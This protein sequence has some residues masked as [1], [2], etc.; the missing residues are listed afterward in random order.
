MYIYIPIK[1]RWKIKT[2]RIFHS[3]WP[4][5]EQSVQL[6]LLDGWYVI[7]LSFECLVHH[8]VFSKQYVIL[9]SVSI[10]ILPCL[11]HSLWGQGLWN[12]KN[13]KLIIISHTSIKVKWW[14]SCIITLIQNTTDGTMLFVYPYTRAAIFLFLNNKR[15]VDNIQIK[16]FKVNRKYVYMR[17]L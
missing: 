8:L 6:I 17:G 13:M 4:F 5:L 16:N 12:T 2:D 15:R 10:H 3:P 1:K 7:K 11:Q 9:F 14:L